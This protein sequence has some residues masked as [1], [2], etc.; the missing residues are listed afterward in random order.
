[1]VI[2]FPISIDPTTL[3]DGVQDTV[4]FE[5]NPEV[6]KSNYKPEDMANLL[7]GE[8]YQSLKKDLVL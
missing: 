5:T 8:T 7:P 4:N 3:P 6:R 2:R 1:V